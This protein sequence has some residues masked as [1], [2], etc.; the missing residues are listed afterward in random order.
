MA[1]LTRTSARKRGEYL[2]LVRKFPLRPIRSEVQLRAAHKIID[3]LTR[4]PEE[5]LTRD[6]A[7][8][9][10]VL[11]DLA[12]A[13][14]DRIMSPEVAPVTGLDVLNHL[15]DANDMS[16]SDLGRLLGH[17]ELGSK[18]VRG[19]R[20]ISKSHAKALGEHF[21]LPPETFLRR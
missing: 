17:R 7:D 3:E 21:G 19:E 20:E 6:Q 18:I 10:E 16:A 2:E 8:Y 9:L 15:M 4:I 14:E 13:Y 5:R 11:G 1:V 12:S